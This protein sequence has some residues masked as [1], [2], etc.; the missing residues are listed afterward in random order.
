MRFLPG[1]SVYFPVSGRGGC[2]LSCA[3]P[4]Y[5]QLADPPA[6]AIFSDADDENA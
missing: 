4:Q 5:A 1:P 2:T 3:S 6:A